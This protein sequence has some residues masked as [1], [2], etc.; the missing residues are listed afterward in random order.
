[1]T[2]DGPDLAQATVQQLI[3]WHE[4]GYLTPLNDCIE[5]HNEFTVVR[6]NLWPFVTIDD[7]IWAVPSATAQGRS[8]P[9]AL[10]SRVSAAR[11]RTMKTAVCRWWQR[12]V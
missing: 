6:K 11:P 9:N 12:P 7:Q 1:M 10:G 2:G 4:A 3:S 5:G 8:R